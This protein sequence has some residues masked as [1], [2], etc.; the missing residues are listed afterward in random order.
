MR[1]LNAAAVSAGLSGFIW[2]AWADGTGDRS[3]VGMEMPPKEPKKKS[4]RTRKR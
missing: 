4:A 1:D 3:S 2:F